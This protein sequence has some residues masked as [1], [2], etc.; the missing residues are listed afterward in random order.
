MMERALKER[1]IGA[2]VLVVFVVL[3]VPIFLDG[4]PA[5]G[6]I[7]SQRVLLPGQEGQDTKTV[8]LN[9]ERSEPIPVASRAKDPATEQANIAEPEVS[10]TVP[11][12]VPE[13]STARGRR[14]AARECRQLSHKQLLR[15]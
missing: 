11:P 3:V 6:E 1:I 2:I 13:R 4:P 8:I 12:P 7:V 10:K 9:P 5:D 14:W 15:K